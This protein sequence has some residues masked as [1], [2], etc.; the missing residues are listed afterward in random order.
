MV[1]NSILPK[2]Q[3]VGSRNKKLISNVYLAAYHFLKSF[4]NFNVSFVEI[5]QIN[6]FNNLTIWVINSEGR[7]HEYNSIMMP[8][9]LNK[10]IKIFGTNKL[11][12]KKY[13]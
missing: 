4:K 13:L 11:I 3:P 7:I 10:C 12:F 8:Y 5:L 6:Y 1:S 2:H 9:S